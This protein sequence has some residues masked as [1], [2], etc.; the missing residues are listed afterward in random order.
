MYGLRYR[1]LRKQRRNYGKLWSVG[2]TVTCALDLERG[3][4]RYY[5]NGKDLGVAFT[6]LDVTKTWYPAVSLSTG[7][8]C[9]FRFGG[10]L[11]KIRYTPIWEQSLL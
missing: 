11:D 2:T 9:R 1:L 5:Q 7:Q 3:E 10:V 8:E 4:I 6:D